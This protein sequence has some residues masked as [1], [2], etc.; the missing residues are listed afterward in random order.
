MGCGTG[1]ADGWA[2]QLQAR[3][4]RALRRERKAGPT[5]LVMVEQLRVEVEG[6]GL[7]RQ[8]AALAAG[9][10]SLGPLGFQPGVLS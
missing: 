8:H 2:R 9:F 6:H 3:L 5:P 10:A 4:A 1:A 7:A